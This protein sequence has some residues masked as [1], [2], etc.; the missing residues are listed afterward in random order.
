MTRQSNI[1][2]FADVQRASRARSR[3]QGGRTASSRKANTAR[4]AARDTEMRSYNVYGDMPIGSYSSGRISSRDLD[5]SPFAAPMQ[6]RKQS[7]NRAK[8]KTSSS[9]ASSSKKSTAKSASRTNSQPIARNSRD[10]QY[11]RGS[12]KSTRK[13][14][15]NRPKSVREF[16]ASIIGFITGST[17]TSAQQRKRARTKAKA[18]RLFEKTFLPKQLAESS[19]PRAAVYKGEMGAKQRKSARMQKASS[20]GSAMA[21]I[22]PAGWLTH[23]SISTAHARLA[24]AAICLVM[25]FA[26]L[27]APAQH[28]YQAQR[29]ND[30]LQAEYAA[31]EQRN[32]ALDAQN[33]SLGSDAGMEDV[34]RQKYGYI[35]EGEETARV[36]GLSDEARTSVPGEGVYASVLSS[37]VK[38]PEYWYT[39]FLDAL[40]GVK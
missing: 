28:Y 11:A 27:Y 15:G 40:F 10:V 14:S 39:P 30:R 5:S 34:I 7:G 22:N 18:D 8:S 19:G 33:E 13:R 38:A 31:V 9:K 32:N 20:A 36:T 23:F 1:V 2:S 24:T 37:T 35:V 12:E 26:F 16:F 4:S 21:K 17:L 3:T 25:V 29:E 6:T